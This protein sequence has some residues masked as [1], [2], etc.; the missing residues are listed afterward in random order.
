MVEQELDSLLGAL[1]DPTRRAIVARLAH[2][3]RTVGD[4]AAPF[5]MSLAAISKHVHVLDRAGLVSRTRRGRSVECRL[6]PQR[7]R[8]VADWINDYEKFW[9]ERLDEL[10]AV[11]RKNRKKSS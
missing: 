2:G 11:I 8:A 6:E 4:L 5:D 9:N 7:L 3:P 1:A 10:E